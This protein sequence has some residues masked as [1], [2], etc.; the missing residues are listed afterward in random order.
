MSYDAFISYSHGADSELAEAL[1]SGLQRLSKPWYRRS[2]FLHVF[3][4]ETSFGAGHEL[5][6]A[7][8]AALDD[9]E[10][11]V[12]L[13]SPRSASSEWVDQ[14]IGQ[15]LEARGKEH[16][17]FVIT[18]WGASGA[19]A[20]GSGAPLASL[21][22]FDW[23]GAD[24]PPSVRGTFDEPLAVDMRQYAGRPETMTL[25]SDE[26]RD[27]V[28]EVAA[29]VKGVNK[30]ELIGAVVAMRTRARILTSSILLGAAILLVAI[31]VA[32]LGWVAAQNAEER[33][34]AGERDAL[35]RQASAEE[36]AVASEA[37]AD[38][39]AQ[40]QAAAED[41]LATTEGE[42]AGARDELAAARGDVEAAREEL[43]AATSEAEQARADLDE[44]RVRLETTEASLT[45]TEDE[46]E[47]ARGDLT[48]AQ[49]NLAA[50]ETRLGDA[51]R[52][53]RTTEGRLGQAQDELERVEDDLEVA[54]ADAA[55]Q[56][57]VVESERLATTSGDV[58]A[59][60]E[61]A[62]AALL[63]I[64]SIETTMGQ[65]GYMT[66]NARAAASAASHAPWRSRL[67]GHS[68]AV[69][70]MAYS[71]D[72][73]QLA[74]GAK[75]G[76]VVVWNP[77]TG[78]QISSFSVGGQVRSLE[79]SADS[80]R[81]LAVSSVCPGRTC[82]GTIANVWNPRD[83]QRLGLLDHGGT[84]WFA[85][86]S[87]DG[88][89][90]VTFDRERTSIWESDGALVAR[91]EEPLPTD[92]RSPVVRPVLSP[93]GS[94]VVTRTITGGLTV[95]E[96][97]T[98]Q[99][100]RDIGLATNDSYAQF[101][102]DGGSLLTVAPPGVGEDR[103]LTR[104]DLTT[105]LATYTRA[106]DDASRVE[107]SVSGSRALTPPLGGRAVEV[108]DTTTG[109]TTARL[110]HGTGLSSAA[111][112]PDGET[113]VTIAPDEFKL[114]D[115][116]DG[117]RLATIPTLGPELEATVDFNADG[118]RVVVRSSFS[119]EVRVWSR[120]GVLLSSARRAELTASAW[121]P[122][123]DAVALGAD[124]GTL[125]MMA[126]DE[127]AQMVAGVRPVISPDGAMIATADSADS[128]IDVYR[129][130]DPRR[131][132]FT[133]D[134]VSAVDF[135]ADSSL[136][137]TWTGDV[138]TV[139]RASD[140]SVVHTLDH[141]GQIA[142][143]EFAPGGSAVVTIGYDGRARLW[144]A[145]GRPVGTAGPWSNECGPFATRLG[146]AFSPDGGRIAVAGVDTCAQEVSVE[147]RTASTGALIDTLDLGRQTND[148][149]GAPL[150]LAFGPG[151]GRLAVVG[152]SSNASIWGLDAGTAVATLVGHDENVMSVA[153]RPDGG[154]I[155]TSSFDG[156]AKVWDPNG[157]P[158]LATLDLGPIRQIGA[159]IATS[160]WYD[161][162]G[163]TIVTNG[164]FTRLWHA[165]GVQLAELASSEFGINRAS[166]HPNGDVLA[167]SMSFGSG[168]TRVFPLYGSGDV[169]DVLRSRL[170]GQTLTAA[171]CD[172]YGVSRC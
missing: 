17:T 171:Q 21:A 160:A 144:S 66:P 76:T 89:R 109:A 15:F 136:L 124:D 93:D 61:P 169:V 24:V 134:G 54:S 72:G 14:E 117:T 46:L 163:D 149:T 125:V 164:N 111:F 146:V 8:S 95:W 38:E 53:L 161:V 121:H 158:A 44:A 106:L 6:E 139:R 18:D 31:L 130:A 69:L 113:I 10:H 105:G 116:A 142:Q 127:A 162:S 27:D 34:L 80:T 1:Q 23:S 47:G 19:G 96:M 104:W 45:A 57:A 71:P 22:A 103:E 155:V 20:S 33:A 107:F 11:L 64:E 70:A 115:A 68:A 62:T 148:G 25:D 154:A 85:Q 94:G 108:F 58:L 5:G 138:A 41:S 40:R 36:A 143:A 73:A 81:L 97:A 129:L 122:Q 3:R 120:S 172:R 28:A 67:N 156:T 86:F 83:G 52:N 63:A 87:V 166:L 60:G 128:R 74:S 168:P 147:V 91:L 123:G 42:L 84:F 98:G 59:L 77:S 100:V 101:S 110:D 39:A 30:D 114:W 135:S 51:E 99:R 48:D 2:P 49:T 16:I 132:A 133:L 32:G 170:G 145:A 79:Y 159:G 78:S 88:D 9:S 140:R 119:D 4:D 35:V 118:S 151:G 152:H 82:T 7:I 126:G 50:A 137:L 43:E 26:F 92:P 165:S 75:D 167:V 55:E 157:G 13:L 141:G 56:R 131:P 102:N 65:Y 37:A 112:S 150:A 29:A 12:V 153:Y 90:I